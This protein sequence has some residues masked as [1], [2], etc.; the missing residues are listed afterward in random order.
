MRLM[1]RIENICIITSPFGC[2]PPNAIGAVEKRWKSCGDYFLEKGI[3]VT[4]LSKRPCK[5]DNNTVHNIY[6]KGYSWTGSKIKDL[7]LDFVYSFKALWKMPK[8][9]AVVLNTIFTPVLL[10]LFKWKYKVSLYNVARFPKKQLGMYR[11]VDILS[12]VSNVVY[13]C[14]LEQTPSTKEQGCVINNFI[15]TDVFHQRRKH[16]RTDTPIVLFTGRVHREKGLELLVKAINNVRKTYN[17]SLKI[18]GAWEVERGGSGYDYVEELNGLAAGWKIDWV[19]PVYDPKQLA[20]EMDKCD[21]YCYPSIADKGET[22]GVA[23]LEAMGLGLPTIVSALECF[24]DFL[25]DKESGLVFDHHSPDAVKQLAD[26]I[27][28]ILESDKNYDILSKNAFQAAAEFTIENKA[29]EYICVM[30]NVLNY[31]RL[32]FDDK[33]MKVRQIE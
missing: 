21:I 14:M 27:L 9:D 20:E 17:V 33:L 7:I 1:K 8:C 31:G 10:P 23:P 2:I 16:S 28:Y 24:S 26:C 13:N 29:E 3:N 25:K 12:C 5:S 30:N 11:A 18:I 4:F 32:G 6:I 22:F 19:A 15:N